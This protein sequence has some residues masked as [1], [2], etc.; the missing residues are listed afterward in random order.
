MKVR[1]GA[2]T[3]AG[4]LLGLVLPVLVLGLSAGYG[5][6]GASRGQAALN[7]TNSGPIALTHDDRF[8][9]VANPERVWVNQ[10]ND[11]TSQEV[12]HNDDDDRPKPEYA[13]IGGNLC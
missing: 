11:D 2:R 8:V 1:S 7:P 3:R 9:W 12:Q 6:S 10:V 5:K 4:L 13:N